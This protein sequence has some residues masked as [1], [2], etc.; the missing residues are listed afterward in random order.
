M[1]ECQNQLSL[2]GTETLT[3]SNAQLSLLT[4]QVKYLTTE[5]S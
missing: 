2:L 3:D 5:F 1:E 4:L